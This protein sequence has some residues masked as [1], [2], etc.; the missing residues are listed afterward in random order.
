MNFDA[1]DLMF[2]WAIRLVII[3]PLFLL[4]WFSLRILIKAFSIGEIDL[5][6]YAE[7]KKDR[8][9]IITPNYLE[10][11][12]FFLGKILM[13]LGFTIWALL[14]FESESILLIILNALL[15]AKAVFFI[16]LNWV[17]TANQSLLSRK[18]IYC[19]VKSKKKK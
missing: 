8:D 1:L 6:E 5:D 4:F 11:L 13:V 14:Q 15:P 3:F 17:L 16:G 19:L 9:T 2:Y 12:F 10:N 18:I 7:R